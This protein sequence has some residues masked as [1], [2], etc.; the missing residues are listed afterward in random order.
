MEVLLTSIPVFLLVFIRVLSFFLVIPIF[1]YRTIPARV[2]IGLAL[3]LAYVIVFT[4]DTDPI[5]FDMLYIL[6]VIKEAIAGIALGLIGYIILS[7]VQIA[8]GFIDFQMGF[9]IANV[10][11]PQTGAQ[12]PILGQYLYIFAFLFLLSVNGHHLLIDGIYQSYQ[13]IPIDQPF[14][15]F[16]DENT[17]KLIGKV[18]SAMFIIGFQM[19]VPVVAS[20]FLI[21]VALGIVARTVPQMNIFVVGFPVKILVGI[22]ILFIVMGTM[23][24]SVKSLFEL[25]LYSLRDLMSLL[26]G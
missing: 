4:I 20:L 12:S 1:S 24:F 13:F 2:K 5:E 3:Y 7:A 17:V 21:D 15:H 26:G 23:I 19:S 11:D 10:I 18:F 16:G 8:G 14:L 25:L 9:A 22:I 6:L